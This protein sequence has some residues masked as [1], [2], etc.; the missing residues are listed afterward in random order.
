MKSFSS[1]FSHISV[2]AESSLVLS[3]TPSAVEFYDNVA[4][5]SSL[6]FVDQ[7]ADLGEIGG[8]DLQ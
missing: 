3:T 7:D 4:S 6:S 5:V 2:F 8:E 1:R